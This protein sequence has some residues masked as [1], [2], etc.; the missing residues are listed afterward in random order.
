MRVA[1]AVGLASMVVSIGVVFAD[2]NTP[3]CVNLTVD[4][5]SKAARLVPAGSRALYYCELCGDKDPGP[6]QDITEVAIVAGT[7]AGSRSLKVNGRVVDIAY[8][9]YWDSKDR[10][11]R[12]VAS[13]AGCPVHG[14]QRVLSL[15]QNAPARQYRMIIVVDIM[16]TKANGNRWDP[17]GDPPDPQFSGD[18]YNGNV[19]MMKLPGNP[20]QNDT[21][22]GTYD[23][24]VTADANN[25]ILFSVE[26]W[27]GMLSPDHIGEVRGRL[28]DAINAGGKPVKLETAGQ[29]SSATVRLIP[30]P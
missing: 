14:V 16:P 30:T 12:N 19:H 9:Y 29:I 23:A 27:D 11:G 24:I 22:Q 21:F 20:Y 7:G 25:A 10:T 5:A 2:P 4:Q 1:L 8:V 28:A 15:R 26:D 6:W 17:M 18:L 3:Q 13:D